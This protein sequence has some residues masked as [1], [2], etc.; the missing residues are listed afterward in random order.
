[1]LTTE[2]MFIGTPLLDHHSLATPMA[3]AFQFY[4]LIPVGVA[5]GRARDEECEVMV[6]GG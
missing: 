5:Q 4:S 2:L 1:M 3:H 6:I